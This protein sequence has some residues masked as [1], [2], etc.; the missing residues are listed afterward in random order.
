MRMVRFGSILGKTKDWTKV[1]GLQEGKTVE[2]RIHSISIFEPNQLDSIQVGSIWFI[3]NLVS[4]WEE[5]QFA[6]SGESMGVV[7]YRT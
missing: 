3:T 5:K 4:E 6:A 1:F 2:N 7:D